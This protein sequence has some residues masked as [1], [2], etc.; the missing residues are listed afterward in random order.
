MSDLRSNSPGIGP[1][2]VT[3]LGGSCQQEP[4]H[5]TSRSGNR[6]GL[7]AR[8]R[9]PV[10]ATVEVAA[11]GDVLLGEVASV[12]PAENGHF[13]LIRVKYTMAIGELAEREEEE[14]MRSSLVSLLEHLQAVEK[15]A[16][17]SARTDRNRSR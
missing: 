2:T 14:A 5:V 4:V 12:E 6:I 9:L 17:R 1:A 3:T 10:G 8:T 16:P 15:P 7:V 13:A 11:D